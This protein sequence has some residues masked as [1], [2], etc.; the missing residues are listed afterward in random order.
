MKTDTLR[1]VRKLI[2]QESENMGVRV[3]EYRIV[4]DI[5]NRTV[6]VLRIGHRSVLQ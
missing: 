1:G 4:F 3:G 2:D 6:V 5:R